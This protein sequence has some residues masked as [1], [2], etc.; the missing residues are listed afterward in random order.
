MGEFHSKQLG[1]GSMVGRSAMAV[2]CILLLYVLSIGPACMLNKRGL[3]PNGVKMAYQ[4]LVPVMARS[5][6]FAH[7]LNQYQCWWLGV[8][9]NP[10]QR[11]NSP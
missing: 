11:T 6:V 1:I 4:P 9:Y 3:L 10:V 5:E 8:P 2:L 7:A